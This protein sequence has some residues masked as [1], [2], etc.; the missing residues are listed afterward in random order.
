MTLIRVHRF[1]AEDV[2]FG[3]AA[4]VIGRRAVSEVAA[5]GATGGGVHARRALKPQA[6]ERVGIEEL[7]RTRR[8]GRR[9]LVRQYWVARGREFDD[10]VL[11]DLFRIRRG[12]ATGCQKYFVLE[13]ERAWM[14]GLPEEYLRPMLPSPRMLKATVI[15]R[16]TTVIRC[17]TRNCASLTATWRKKAVA[18]VSG[19][20]GNITS[21]NETG[22]HK[23]YLAAPRRPCPAGIGRS[24]GSRRR[25]C[26]RTWVAGR[27]S[28]G[29]SGCVEPLAGDGVRNLYLLMTPVGALQ[30]MLERH[31]ERAADVHALLN[32][33]TGDE[34]RAAGR[35]YGGGLHKIEP[36]ELARLSASRFVET[37][38]ELNH[39]IHG[40]NGRKR[41]TA[42]KR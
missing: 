15:E 33:I 29:R 16:A 32:A 1:E 30:A 4:I 34:L 9:I 3:D 37:W 17:S 36:R 6:R 27:R 31:P 8:S 12:I 19:G 38:K 10:V 40:S 26:A 35:V 13:R 22:V 2:Q 24:S 14:L 42:N 20:N 23:S 5:G 21:R 41:G 25:F 28:G 18:A 7:R 11:A 39:G